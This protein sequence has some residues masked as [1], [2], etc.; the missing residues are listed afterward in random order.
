MQTSEKQNAI[1]VKNRPKLYHDK[2]AN[3]QFKLLQ[4]LTLVFFLNFFLTSLT[5]LEFYFT[6]VNSHLSFKKKKEKKLKLY[7]LTKYIST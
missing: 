5:L 1:C 7:E 4:A 6:I 3:Q 2:D